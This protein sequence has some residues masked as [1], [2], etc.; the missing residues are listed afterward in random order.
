MYLRNCF[1]SAY[2]TR[3]LDRTLELFRHEYGIDHFIHFEPDMEVITPTGTGT[4][5]CRA[6]LGWADRQYVVEVIQPIGG[7]ADIYSAFLPVDDSP[8]LHHVAMRTDDWD[9]LHRQIQAK[10]WTIAVEAHM[11]EGLKFMY[12]DARQQVGHYL[13]YVWATPEMWQAI[14]GAA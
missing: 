9:G 1:Q 6:A 4:L 12:I 3:D 8:R 2:V 11:P 10:G 7:S 13:E 5:T 14:G